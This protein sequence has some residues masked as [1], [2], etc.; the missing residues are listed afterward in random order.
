MEHYDEEPRR[1]LDTSL[2][3]WNTQPFAYYMERKGY[4]AVAERNK[5]HLSTFR[6]EI[7]LTVRLAELMLRQ[8]KRHD[9]WGRQEWSGWWTIRAG[10]S[11]GKY[12]G[13]PLRVQN[14]VRHLIGKYVVGTTDRPQRTWHPVDDFPFF[15]LGWNLVPHL[16]LDVDMDSH[17]FGERAEGIVKELRRERAV[18]QDLGFPFWAFRTGRRGH[19]AVLPLPI[20]ISPRDASYLLGGYVRLLELQGAGAAKRAASR[21]TKYDTDNLRSLLRLPGGLHPSVQNLGLWIDIDAGGLY[22]LVEQ[23]RLMTA[24]FR[25]PRATEAGL[26]TPDAFRAAIGEVRAHLDKSGV[27]EGSLLEPEQVEAV[28]AALPDNPLVRR[29]RGAAQALEER[30]EERRR[31]SE[32]RKRDVSGR[33]TPAPPAVSEGATVWATGESPPNGEEGHLPEGVP[34]LRETRTPEREPRTR[35]TRE[36][37]LQVWEDGFAPGGFWQWVNTG[38]KKGIVA[39][40]ILFGVEGAVDAMV[41]L[42]QKVPYRSESDLKDRIQTIRGLW[43]TF[44]WKPYVMRPPREKKPQVL[45]TGDATEEEEAFALEVVQEML[46]RKK[47]RARWSPDLAERVVLI[48]LVALR[49]AG[50]GVIEISYRDLAESVTR[51]WPDQKTN[52]MSVK[53]MVHRLTEGDEESLF[54]LLHMTP[55]ATWRSQAHLYRAGKE[56]RATPLGGHGGKI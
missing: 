2:F 21:G 3:G 16:R 9:E 46:R 41:D 30:R 34:P 19:Q 29:M 44:D 45:V 40:T 22:D 33:A 51:R 8:I 25:F 11:T 13:Q 38:G 1:E 31:Q 36:W 52:H 35:Y 49:E 18:A 4:K 54:A 37:A 39:A 32:A 48:L 43:K 20:P 47:P 50:N 15:E 55:G 24:G 7:P 12:P 6:K 5:P 27:S 23:A 53:E 14:L 17:W 28:G 56:L 42:A 26:W 10:L